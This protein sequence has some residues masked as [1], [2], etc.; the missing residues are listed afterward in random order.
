MVI[1]LRCQFKVCCPAVLKTK[2]E[3]QAATQP[4]PTSPPHVPAAAATGSGPDQV[5]NASP[6][7][8]PF[9]PFVL[10]LADLYRL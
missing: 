7:L 6:D 9:L 8:T 1:S 4:S 2:Q 3:G 5:L 10:T